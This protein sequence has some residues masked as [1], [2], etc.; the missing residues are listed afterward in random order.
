VD[1]QL[2]AGGMCFVVLER[3]F[4]AP[5]PLPPMSSPVPSV[6]NVPAAPDDTSPEHINPTVSDPAVSDPAVFDPTMSDDDG[7]DNIDP[8]TSSKTGSITY[9]RKKNG[10]HLEWE[11]RAD[12]NTWLM[13]K[14]AAIGIEIQVSKTW[15]SKSK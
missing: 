3:I 1:K 11:S 12:F 14:Q 5:S 6:V 4:T 15:A 8:A 7:H 13:H 9:D 10:Y 2:H